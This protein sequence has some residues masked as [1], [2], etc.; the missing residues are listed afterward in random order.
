MS[1]SLSVSV[2]G[3]FLWR[4]RWEDTKRH[5]HQVEEEPYA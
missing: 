3:Q 4:W 5:L 2:G 1:V